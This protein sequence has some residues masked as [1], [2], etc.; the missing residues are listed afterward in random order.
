MRFELNHF[1][2][3]CLETQNSINPYRKVGLKYA[4]QIISYRIKHFVFSHKYEDPAP[5]SM[6]HLSMQIH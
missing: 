5:T 2:R 3:M 6:K 1:T 4:L